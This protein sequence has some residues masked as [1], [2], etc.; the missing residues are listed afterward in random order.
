[1]RIG[2][3]QCQELK[4]AL[5]QRHGKTLDIYQRAYCSS[6]K[7]VSFQVWH[8]Y[9]G[10]IPPVNAPVDAWIISGSRHSVNDGFAWIDA[11]SDFIRTMWQQQKPVVGICFGHQIIAR[12]MGGKVERFAGGWGLGIDSQQIFSKETWMY[13]F[14]KSMR[15]PVIHQ[16]Q[17]VTKPQDATLVAGNDFCQHHMLRYG[18][19]FLTIQG[20]PEFSVEFVKDV[21]NLMRHT[22]SEE[23][24]QKTQRSLLLPIDG[25]III[26][27]IL[28]FF[29]Q[30][31]A[32]Q[33][34]FASSQF[35]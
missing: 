9:K 13:P 26:H 23:T 19:C 15:I 29:Q 5:S 3:I 10:E 2:L 8:A 31:M 16:D 1:M 18:D 34:Q 7:E 35:A 30:K 17:V 21:T 12:A 32:S 24:F 28:N 4:D 6:D 33:Q 22:L 14:K 11:L 25:P 20:H 27:W